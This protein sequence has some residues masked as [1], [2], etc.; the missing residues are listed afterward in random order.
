[1]GHRA[2]RLA[3]P[4][5]LATWASACGPSSSERKPDAVDDAY[6]VCTAMMNTNLVSKCD[7]NGWNSSVDVRIDTSGEEAIKICTSS[8]EQVSQY[9]ERLTGKWKLRVYSPFSGDNVLAECPF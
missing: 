1:M 3:F 6:R 8:V 4:I 2:I 9:T 5:I 7:V